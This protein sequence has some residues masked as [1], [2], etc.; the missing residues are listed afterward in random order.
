MSFPLALFA[1]AVFTQEPVIVANPNPKVPLAA[2]VKFSA[3]QAVDTTIQVSDGKHKWELHYDRARKP[4]DGLPVVGMRPGRK[5][6]ITV[7]IGKSSK[8]L[9]YTTPGLP[10]ARGEFPPI[11]VT[12]GQGKIEP[13]IT[14]LC[15]RRQSAGSAAGPDEARFGML[16]A[17]DEDGEVVWYYKSD[18]RISDFEHRENGAILLLTV[19][20]RLV[21]IDVLGNE[22]GSWF[23]AGRPG[24]AIAV[25]PVDTTAFHHEVD[26]T[27]K[28]N[29]IVLGAR[30]REIDNYYTSET[31]PNAPRKKQW[32]MGDEIIEFNRDG[33]ILWKWNAFDHLDPFRIGYETF[34]GY[35]ERAGF[36]GTIDW[37]HGNSLF[38]DEKDDSVT[39]SL[40]YQSAVLKI[41][42]KTGGIRWILGEPGGWPAALEKKLLKPVGELRWPWH[43]HGVTMAGRASVLV[44][45]NGNYGARPFTAPVAPAKTNSRAVEYKVDEKKM[46]VQQVWES[47][48]AGGDSVVS[49]AMGNPEWQPKTGNVLVVYGGLLPMTQLAQADPT[50]TR[51]REWTHTKPARVVW[52]L[53]IEDSSKE[54]PVGWQLFCGSRW[55]NL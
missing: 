17:V 53:V 42:R 34:S 25:V 20:H 43:Q 51:V 14:L 4:D 27:G 36:P 18:V 6:E 41:D 38:Y 54:K 48:G 45:D 2:V 22:I 13:G 44:Y 8:K 49:T 5:H 35:Y 9:E 16:V 37:T 33:K 23:A 31:D 1:A 29:L 28:G 21:E 30:R 55:P 7:S 12:K 3:D 47:D 40:C 19:D 10:A 46:T 52:E 26:E 11:K 50:W 24:G 15:V 39:V 32:V